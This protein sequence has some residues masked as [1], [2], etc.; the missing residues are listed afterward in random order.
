MVPELRIA[1]CGASGTGKTTLAKWLSTEYGF[2][3]NPIGARHVASLLGFESPYDVDKA[4]R[5]SEFQSL[6][7]DMKVS[8]ESRRNSF[9]TDRTTLD[10]LTYTAIHKPEA[11]TDEVIGKT[12]EGLS[13]YTHII[14]CP[15]SEFIKLDTDPCRMGDLDYQLE[16]DSRLLG[17]FQRYLPDQS[18][19]TIRS[20]DREVRKHQLTEMLH[21]RRKL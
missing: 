21:L 17:L 16:Y 7:I 20:N 11:V 4:G 3:F 1:F 13:R 18:P 8:W 19:V 5:R 15:V 10:N 14:H 2:E 6:L 12:L 9:V